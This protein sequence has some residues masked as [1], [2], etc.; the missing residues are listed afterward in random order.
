MVSHRGRLRYDGGSKE[1][2]RDVRG[3]QPRPAA[4]APS[5]RALPRA[6]GARRRRQDDPGREAGEPGCAS[7]GFDVVA[8]RDP[9]STDVGD[10]LREIVLDRDSSTCRSGPRCSST[11][12]A[13]HSSSTR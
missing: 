1:N 10:R 4:T 2:H 5:S 13:G 11:W 6:G 7:D 9:G 3:I 8:C 12:P